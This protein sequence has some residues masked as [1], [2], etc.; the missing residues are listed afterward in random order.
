MSEL[1]GE[2]R[3]SWRVDSQS[4]ADVGTSQWPGT[5]RACARSRPPAGVELRCSWPARGG[6][7]WSRDTESH[8]WVPVLRPV[9]SIMHMIVGDVQCLIEIEL[10]SQIRPGRR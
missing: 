3:D 10:L 2:R 4:C 9:S 5:R 7:F 6:R 1:I 8:V